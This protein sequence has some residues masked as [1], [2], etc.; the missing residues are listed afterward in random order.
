MSRACHDQPTAAARPASK[1]PTI[2]HAC[3][4]A[5]HTLQNKG[6][7]GGCALDQ[8]GLAIHLCLRRRCN[9]PG[10]LAVRAGDPCLVLPIYVCR[11]YAHNWHEGHSVQ[12]LA[13]D[14]SA[15]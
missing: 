10:P 5:A 14:A 12:W 13:V 15:A 7:A 2:A 8:G 1:Q 3:P 11:L 9:M 6:D 4:L